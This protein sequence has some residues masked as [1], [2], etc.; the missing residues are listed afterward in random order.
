MALKRFCLG[1][2]ALFLLFVSCEWEAYTDPGPITKREVVLRV[3]GQ[4]ATIQEAIDAS[5]DGD[6]ILVAAGSFSGDGNTNIKLRNKPVILQSEK[7]PD[8]TIID[9]RGALAFPRRGFIIYSGEDSTTVIEG[10]TVLGGRAT[11]SSERQSWGGAVFVEFSSPKFVN[12]IFKSGDAAYGGAVAC[13]TSSP[14]FEDC[15][16]LLNS[17]S[18]EGGGLKCDGGA[19]PKLRNCR[20][21]GNNALERGGGI[22]L[23][24]SSANIDGCKFTGNSASDPG[25]GGAICCINSSPYVRNSIF[26]QNSAEDG[27]AVYCRTN[28]NPILE[29]C[30]VLNNT[31]AG[32]VA[33]SGLSSNSGSRPRV[34]YCLFVGGGSGPA[35]SVSDETNIPVIACTNLHGNSGGN[36]VGLIADQAALRGNLSVDPLFCDSPVNENARLDASS[37]CWPENN[38]CNKQIGAFVT[39]CDSP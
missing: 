30:T 38:S 21:Q 28:A 22:S 19:S 2:T 36:W 15:V 31:S 12:C 32:A 13:R 27:G 26:F 23:V 1:C 34:D 10:F 3:P 5:V 39:N 17:A 4:Y 18:I 6:T 11:E 37:P 25:Y 8:S 33:G 24:N 14:I 7:G 20:I 29:N 9:C 16:F 35:I